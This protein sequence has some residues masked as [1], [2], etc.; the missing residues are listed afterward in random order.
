MIVFDSFFALY[1]VTVNTNE[2]ANKQ[3]QLALRK[4][5]T[6]NI[7]QNWRLN[8][9]RYQLVGVRFQNG[10]GE[11]NFPPRTVEPVRSQDETEMPIRLEVES[12]K[13]SLKKSLKLD[14]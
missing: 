10:L 4:I 7:A 14:R 3:R 5:T 2:P 11:V 6:M 9:Q 8:K 12:I 13:E 1:F